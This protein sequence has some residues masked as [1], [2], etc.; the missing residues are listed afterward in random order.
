MMPSV[1][2]NEERKP[3][4]RDRHVGTDSQGRLQTYTDSDSYNRQK[5]NRRHANG[6]HEI[7][8]SNLDFFFLI[9]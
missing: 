4:V 2:F 3:F 6:E 8:N 7:E 5:K 1:M 9:K